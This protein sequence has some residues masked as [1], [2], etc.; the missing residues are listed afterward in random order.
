LPE[1]PTETELAAFYGEDEARR[2]VGEMNTFARIAPDVA[3][4]RLATE[5]EAGKILAQYTPNPGSDNFE[6]EAKVQE[7]VFGAWQQAKSLREADPAGFLA[8]NS[9]VVQTRAAAVA[10][11]QQMAANAAPEQRAAAYEAMQSKG[12]AYAAFLLEEQARIGIP[13][14]KRTLLPAAVAVKVRDDFEGKLAQG[15]VAGAVT[16]IR[17]AVA[18][19]GDAGVHLLPQLGENASPIA[20]FALE[21]LD[22]RTIETL[23]AATRDGDKVL[24]AAVGDQWKDVED[25]VRA[26]LAAFDAT[27]STEYPAYY[28]ATVRIAAA[29]VRAGMDPGSAAAQ[30]ASETINGRYRFG[31]QGTRIDYRVPLAD[32]SG[33]PIDAER[34]MAGATRALMGL[35]PADISITDTVPVGVPVDEFKAWRL[36][37]IQ[38]TGRWLNDG[39]ESG[40][41][42]HWQDNNGRLVVARG[43]DRKPIRRAW[44]ELI[45]QPG[46]SGG[47]DQ[48][49]YGNLPA[50]AQ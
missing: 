1:R 44:A 27:G 41:I 35:Q 26:E 47:V 19:F 40:L 10:E 24:K 6:F 18:Q 2:M 15:D 20:R 12:E 23:A 7:S 17:A 3:R 30:A 48:G 13:F 31:G 22:L 36:R 16:G 5:S 11:A 42:L 32:I 8:Q 50:G 25:G 43:A 45:A 49:V 33:R 38:Q 4:L 46:K 21:G 37:R 39:N 29:K 34:V 28:E 9:P 14:H